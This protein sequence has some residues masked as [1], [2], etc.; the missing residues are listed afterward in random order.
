[1]SASVIMVPMESPI[2]WPALC[3]LAEDVHDVNVSFREA[4]NANHEAPLLGSWYASM[5]TTIQFFCK[6]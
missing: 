5:P 6:E 4:T 2:S 3:S 1:M